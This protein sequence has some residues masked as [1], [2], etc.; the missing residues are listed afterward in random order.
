MKKISLLALSAVAVFA[1]GFVI[2]EAVAQG[3]VPVPYPNVAKTDAK[4]IPDWVDNNFRWYGE[5]AITQSDLLNSLSFLLDNG[6]MHLSDKAAKEMQELREENK[7]LR[8]MIH[9][10]PMMEHD[11][12]HSDDY[13]RMTMK[14]PWGAD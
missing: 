9:D 1:V 10:K 3:P 12:M 14:F 11:D 6:H 2:S 5:G 8:A 13:G 4:A 7:K